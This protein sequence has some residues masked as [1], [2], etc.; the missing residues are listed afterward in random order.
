MLSG[1]VF[2]RTLPLNVRELSPYVEILTFGTWSRFFRI[3]SFKS[4]YI[5]RSYRAAYTNAI[6]C[7]DDC[8]HIKLLYK[9]LTLQASS[10]ARVR[11]PACGEQKKMWHTNVSIPTA[12]IYPHILI[13]DERCNKSWHLRNTLVQRIAE[14][15]L[16]LQ[17][18]HKLQIQLISSS[19][20]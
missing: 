1:K 9:T 6:K 18:L 3:H 14:C 7:V 4:D 5:L 2:Q 10:I 11:V 8:I 16:A 19:V 20:F 13:Q 15:P 17:I 12:T